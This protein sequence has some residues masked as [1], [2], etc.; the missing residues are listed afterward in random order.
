MSNITF[1][2]VDEIALGFAE[3][4]AAT[5]HNKDKISKDAIELAIAWVANRQDRE[6]T[7]IQNFPN[8]QKLA[9]DSKIDFET[10]KK[11]WVISQLE[12]DQRSVGF[13]EFIQE[14][15]SFS[16]ERSF[17]FID[18]N[19]LPVVAEYFLDPKDAEI[20]NVKFPPLAPK[21]LGVKQVSFRATASGPISTPPSIKNFWG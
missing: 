7:F 12:G 9:P 13:Y 15:G 5:N 10:G 4:L 1:E 21:E 3:A 11:Y 16:S 8:W 2:E 18:Y 19:K 14:L 17:Q 20:F 6:K